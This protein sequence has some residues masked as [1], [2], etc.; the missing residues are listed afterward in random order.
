M[1]EWRKYNFPVCPICRTGGHQSS[2]RHCS[3]SG[4]LWIDILS[5]TVACDGCSKSWSL[6][7]S[8]FYCSCGAK[9]VGGEIWEGMAYEIEE[10]YDLYWINA[11][12]ITKGSLSPRFI[13]W[14]K[15]NTQKKKRCFITTAACH[16]LGKPDD[17]P[18]LM[19]LREFRDKELLVTNHGRILVEEYYSIAP[20]I[21]GEIL[22][23][24]N[25]NVIL[26]SLYH[27]W[28]IQCV[29]FIKYKNFELAIGHYKTM[30]NYLKDKYLVRDSDLSK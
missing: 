7:E 12:G 15:S 16:S 8:T 6:E 21:L 14:W 18:E 9:F 27:D 5:G 2:H 19:I 29:E 3:R 22:K 30:V 20:I 4:R 24:E 25:A 17:C 13:G 1:A 10:Y 26:N 23:K 28:I 11:L